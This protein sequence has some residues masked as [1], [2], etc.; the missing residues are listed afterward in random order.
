M[1]SR[2]RGSREQRRGAA[3]VEFAMVVPVVFALIFGMIELSRYVMVQQ[4]LTSA[5]QRG[6]RKATLATTLS[7]QAVEAT[8]R[9]Y[10]SGTLGS[11][12]S[13]D[14]VEISISPDALNAV[15]SGSNV[16]VRIQVNANDISWIQNG[17]VRRT[18]ELVL[19]GE[20]TLVRE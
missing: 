11:L 14:S 16:T 12:A 13:S 5:A 3:L 1:S 20:S 2:R 17:F 9:E 4:A 8:V 7:G 15:T 18:G 10:L 19:A 6:C